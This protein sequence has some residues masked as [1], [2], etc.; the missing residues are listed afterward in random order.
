MLAQ[1]E[2]FKQGKAGADTK[3]LVNV[4][5]TKDN[6]INEALIANSNEVQPKLTKKED[7]PK[8]LVIQLIVGLFIAYWGDRCQISAVVLTATRNLWWG[9]IWWGDWNG[10][11]LCSCIFCKGNA[12][13]QNIRKNN[14]NNRG[15]F[16]FFVRGWKW[17]RGV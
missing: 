8:T 13:G 12:C 7:D 3:F 16:V 5:Q 6:K 1:V 9:G 15:N 2:V 17:K 11:V 4:H 10:S 14:A